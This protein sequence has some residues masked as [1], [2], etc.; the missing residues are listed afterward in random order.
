ML[1]RDSCVKPDTRNSFGISGN[2]FENLPAPN[3]PP[4]GFFGN[5]RST[6]SAHCEPVPLNTVRLAARMDELERST[7][8]IAIPTPRFARKFFNLDSSLSY[9]K[10]LC[11][12][13]HG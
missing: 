5:S 9:K 4:A 12:E 8:N 7:Q 6:A 3:D 11:T 13:L 1:K 2:V 10:S